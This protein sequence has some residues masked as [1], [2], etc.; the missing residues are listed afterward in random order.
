MSEQSPR[1]NWTYPGREDDPWYDGFKDLV[2]AVDGSG[3][4]S[5]ED[6]S[7]VWAGGGTISWDLGAETLTWTDTISIYSPM[8]GKLMQISAG[9]VTSWS[10]GEV[11]F[12]DL[13]RQVLVNTGKTLQKGTTVQSSDDAMALAIRI[14][15]RV[16]FRTGFSLGDGQSST[17]GVAPF[18]ATPTSTDPDAIHV[19]VAAEIDGITAKATPTV[20]DILVIEDAA[21]SNNKKKVLLGNL[22]G[23]STDRFG[24]AIIVGNS[25][26]GD[27]LDQ[28]HYLDTGNGTQLAT[29]IAAAAGSPAKDIW[30]RPGTYDFRNSGGP[31][32]PISVPTDVKV[33]GCG[34]G[35]VVV[36]GNDE[37][38]MGVFSLNDNT[39]IENLEINVPLPVAAGS[40]SNGVVSIPGDNVTCRM[41]KVDF[42]GV[43]TATEANYLFLTAAFRGTSGTAR[44]KIIDCYVDNGPQINQFVS[45]SFY[46]A[47]FL[48]GDRVD[49]RG[50]VTVECDYGVFSATTAMI[51]ESEFY[52]FWNGGVVISS[53]DGSGSDVSNNQF[54]IVSS[55]GS[56]TYGMRL[57][58][59]SRCNVMGNNLNG[60]AGA[61]ASVVG[62]LLVNADLNTINSNRG[63]LWPTSI[64]LDSS[65]DDNIVVGN[66]FGGLPIVN[67]GSGNDL[68][69]NL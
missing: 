58:D 47:Y 53:S 36:I 45:A 4:A 49:I 22:P 23:V 35:N 28:C 33:R 64:D 14:G 65:S 18:P 69:H 21:D 44:A 50:L 1:M 42:L 17:V 60:D 59:T 40:T 29:A 52:D 56:S 34:E 15:D 30:I 43:Y 41:V 48:A 31:S 68:S 51:H 6:R 11:V 20:S 5:R 46:G 12:L 54:T 38:D 39:L 27:T 10:D 8:S 63:Q 66:N 9:T 32:G 19:N 26:A 67:D 55:P 2:I 16:Y 62:V 3:F 61:H 57:V 7:I 13:T 37:G 24:P 25:I